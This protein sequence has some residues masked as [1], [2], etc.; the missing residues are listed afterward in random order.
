MIDLRPVCEAIESE[1][2]HV[3]ASQEHQRWRARQRTRAGDY[4]ILNNSVLFRQGVAAV[5]KSPLYLAVKVA[6]DGETTLPVSVVRPSGQVNVRFKHIPSAAAPDLG[7]VGLV[8]AVTDQLAGLGSIVLALVGEIGPDEPARLELPGIGAG[9]KVLS[10]DPSQSPVAR[11]VGDE[12]AIN[13]LDD[14]DVVWGRAKQVVAE[15]EWC[16]VD[17]L[18]E[19]FEM[20]FVR[21]RELAGKP[22][23]IDRVTHDSSSILSNVVERLSSQVAAYKSALE[24]HTSGS[25]D[26]EALNETLRIAYNFA[27]GTVSLLSLVVGLSDLKPV[28]QWLTFG[29]QSDLSDRFADLP[30]ALVGKAKPSIGLYREV[31]AGARNMTFHDVFAFGRPFVVRLPGEAIREPEL[32]LFRE[33][34]RRHEP[35]LDFGDRKVVELL[36]GLTRVAE[37]PVPI[38]FWESNIKVMEAVCQVAASLQTALTLC[39]N[40]R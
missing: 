19:R 5:A 4:V 30:F 3:L 23:R 34:S 40:V 25:A 36:E 29:A 18:A 14:I 39:A 7:E 32:H 9:M 15:N 24:K 21:L 11:V 38:G 26:A 1:V 10:F 17:R 37:R 13:R 35:A 28:L 33:Y 20:V 27:D 8:D 2:E 16:D 22:I 12:L 6:D 31:I